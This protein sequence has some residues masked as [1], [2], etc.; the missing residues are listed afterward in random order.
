[1]VYTQIIQRFK[2][3]MNIGLRFVLLYMYAHHYKEP[4]SPKGAECAFKTPRYSDIY[5]YIY[6][7]QGKS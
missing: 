3:W 4:Q 2:G 7:S 6:I 1:M 5:M